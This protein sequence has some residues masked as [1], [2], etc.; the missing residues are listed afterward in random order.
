MREIRFFHSIT[1]MG[2]MEPG[3]GRHGRNQDKTVD[4]G[5][6]FRYNLFEVEKKSIEF[7]PGE[8]R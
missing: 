1:G 3:S 8:G 7:H 4:K 5:D 6:G 2:V